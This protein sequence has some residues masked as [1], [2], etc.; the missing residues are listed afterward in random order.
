MREIKFRIWDKV[1]KHMVTEPSISF[2]DHNGFYWK[3]AP[4]Y[5]AKIRS[6]LEAE[7]MQFTGW[8]DHKGQEVYEGDIVQVYS[9]RGVV[10]WDE[11]NDGWRIRV[12]DTYNLRN[13]EMI[14][15]GTIYEHPE[16][17]DI[18]QGKVS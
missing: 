5:G 7:I 14:V 6:D 4:E 16:F 2:P 8:Q 3:D 12:H 15:I 17:L 1:L 13:S 9:Y 10:V 18:S 11:V